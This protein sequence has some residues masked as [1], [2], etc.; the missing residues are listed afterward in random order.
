MKF[1]T[2]IFVTLILALQYPLWLGKGGWLN[3]ISLHKQIDQQ[4]KVNEQIKSEN[5]ILLAVV[6]DLKNGTDVIEGK[7]RF[8]L[9]L[10]KKNETFFLI[11]DKKN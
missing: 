3:V 11:I 8:D 5:D 2:F 7:A 10:I 4:L 1:L 6:Q 9:G